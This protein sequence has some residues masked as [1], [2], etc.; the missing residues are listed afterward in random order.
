MS[1]DIRQ[2]RPGREYRVT[3]AGIGLRFRCEEDTAMVHVYAQQ[4]LVA[5]VGIDRFGGI[6]DAAG[7]RKYLQQR[8]VSV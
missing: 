4:R 8:S 5:R 1:G 2:I 3:V 6:L 7:I